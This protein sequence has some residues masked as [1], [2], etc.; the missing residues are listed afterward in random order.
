MTI[1]SVIAANDEKLVA[2]HKEFQKWKKQ[3][4]ESKKPGTT[5]CRTEYGWALRHF[6]NRACRRSITKC[7]GTFTSRS[8]YARAI[9]T[10]FVMNNKI[11][12]KDRKDPSWKRVNRIPY[13]DRYSGED[14][15]NCLGLNVL[16]GSL[17]IYK[18]AAICIEA[19]TSN[20]SRMCSFLYIMQ[21]GGIKKMFVQHIC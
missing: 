17:S 16:E 14:N 6:H 9:V 4:Q 13:K 7:C 11:Y 5:T 19:R 20:M 10:T 21:K 18:F 8:S 2:V 1:V 15:K 3:R 12:W